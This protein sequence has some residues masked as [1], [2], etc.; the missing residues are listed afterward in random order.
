[1]RPRGTG[2]ATTCQHWIW[3]FIGCPRS[4]DCICLAL[5]PTGVVMHT[6]P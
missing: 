5:I 2:D 1:M 6:P 3:L 4:A